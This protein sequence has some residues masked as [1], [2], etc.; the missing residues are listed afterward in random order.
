MRE[1]R[2]GKPEKGGG[3]ELRVDISAAETV[4]PFVMRVEYDTWNG[5]GSAKYFEAYYVSLFG[6]V[7]HT[8]Q[9]LV[10]LE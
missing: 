8:R 7:L 2:G 10:S 6:V 4:A 5:D 1:I 9:R 3:L